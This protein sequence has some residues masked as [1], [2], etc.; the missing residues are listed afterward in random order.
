M[1]LLCADC[2]SLQSSHRSGA[3]AITTVFIGQRTF[4]RQALGQLCTDQAELTPFAAFDGHVLIASFS[5]A[6]AEWYPS[7]VHMV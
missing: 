3:N 2:P 1:N 7:S 4:A 6:V 5:G